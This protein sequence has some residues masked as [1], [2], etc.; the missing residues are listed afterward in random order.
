MGAR[1][2]GKAERRQVVTYHYA[3]TPDPSTV[4]PCDQRAAER[5]DVSALPA[6]Y[7][8]LRQC[9]GLCS[10]WEARAPGADAGMCLADA[11]D[12]GLHDWCDWWEVRR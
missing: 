4:M 12:R 9:C 2:D 6:G 7:T 5:Q 10:L 3:N 1:R 8:T 11:S